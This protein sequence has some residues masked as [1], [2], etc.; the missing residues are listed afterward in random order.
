MHRVAR[1]VEIVMVIPSWHVVTWPKVVAGVDDW[2]GWTGR[3]R[4]WGTSVE[5][6]VEQPGLQRGQAVWGLDV[7]GS[8]VGVAWEWREVRSNVVAMDDPMVVL[9]NIELHD[10]Q[11]RCLR[12]G[13]RLLALHELIHDL[14]WQDEVSV[15]RGRRAGGMRLAA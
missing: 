8:R 3:F 7:G 9:A 13:Q 11:G 6:D 14:P 12:E 5:D 10:R 4:H 1:S 15:A 2:R